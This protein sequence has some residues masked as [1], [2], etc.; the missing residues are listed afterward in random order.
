MNGV[1]IKGDARSVDHLIT[2]EAK[3]ALPS[4]DKL[5]ALI[6]EKFSQFLKNRNEFTIEIERLIEKKIAEAETNVRRE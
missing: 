6:S 2:S 4:D 1:Y 5:D 3:K